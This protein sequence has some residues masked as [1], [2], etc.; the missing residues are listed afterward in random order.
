MRSG[1]HAAARFMTRTWCSRRCL[2]AL[3]DRFAFV[4]TFKGDRVVRE[5][6]FRNKEEALEAAGLDPSQETG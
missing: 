3:D 1:F 5:Q 6:A 2:I 4:F